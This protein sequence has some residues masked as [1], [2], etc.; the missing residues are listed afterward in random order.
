VLGILDDLFFEED[1]VSLEPGDMVVMFSDGV[2]EAA[3]AQN[4]LFGDKRL[5]AVVVEHRHLGSAAMADA[6]EHSIHSF[7]G[8]EPMRDDVTLLV[9]R[10][11]KS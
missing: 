8:D 10:R 4:Q 9:V 7:A 1:V 11:E 5:E 2:T 6:I 3:N